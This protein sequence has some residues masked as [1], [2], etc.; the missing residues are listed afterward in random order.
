MAV[1]FKIPK[2]YTPPDGTKEGVEFSE[3]ASFKYEG[4]DMMI[5]TIGQDKTPILNRDDKSDKPKSGKQ[6]IKEQLGALEDKKGSSQMEDTE[7]PE[8]EAAPEEEM[9]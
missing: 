9:D 7:S 5:L 6:A 1:S 8:E 2:G 4:G 3:L